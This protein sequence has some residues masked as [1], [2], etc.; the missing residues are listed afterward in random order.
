MKNRTLLTSRKHMEMCCHDNQTPALTHLA[1]LYYWH[2]VQLAYH[3]PVYR[4]KKVG[5]S[6]QFGLV[7]RAAIM[8]TL[9]IQQISVV[10]LISIKSS[11][12]HSARNDTDTPILEY[13]TWFKNTILLSCQIHGLD[14]STFLLFVDERQSLTKRTPHI[15]P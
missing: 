4:N 9:A 14:W 7:N 1:L 5:L 2:E 15:Y 13:F 6:N 12:S 8:H 10:L 11:L 3:L